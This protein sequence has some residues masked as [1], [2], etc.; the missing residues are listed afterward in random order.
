MRIV[1]DSRASLSLQSRLA[2]TARETPVLLA[3]GPEAEQA[4]C[5]KLEDAGCE[6]WRCDAPERVDRLN[7]LLEELGRR[8]MTNLLV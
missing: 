3:V 6:V 8:Q 7:A 4:K 5:R 2:T 1:V